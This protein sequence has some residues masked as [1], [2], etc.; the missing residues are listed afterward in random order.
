MA[1]VTYPNCL[2]KSTI[3]SREEISSHAVHFYCSCNNTKE[4]GATY[5]ITKG[6]DHYLNTPL[7]TTAQIAQL[8]K[9][10]PRQQQLNLLNKN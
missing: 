1:R 2:S 5:R 6:F 9:S 3:T 7:A 8:I 4:C 10:L